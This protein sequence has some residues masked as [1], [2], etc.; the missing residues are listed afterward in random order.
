MLGFNENP[1][2]Q[3]HG[4]KS[5]SFTELMLAKALGKEHNTRDETRQS[6]NAV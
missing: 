5:F 3:A 1:R 2:Y 6:Y 4:R